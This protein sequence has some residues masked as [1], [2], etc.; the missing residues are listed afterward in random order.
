MKRQCELSYYAESDDGDRKIAV[1]FDGVEA[2]RCTYMTALRVEMI[3]IAY[4]Q[5]AR[6]GE[7]DW[8]TEVRLPVEEFH[9][10][11][12]TAPPSLQHLMVCFDDGPCY[13]IICT[14]FTPIVGV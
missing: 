4:D 2:Y 1:I 7:T 11:R 5:I 3:R 8:L 14:G 6:L 13:E 10:R 9:S 12:R